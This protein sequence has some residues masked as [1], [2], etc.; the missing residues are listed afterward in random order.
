MFIVI[1]TLEMYPKSM[2]RDLKEAFLSTFSSLPVLH[3]DNP[4]VLPVPRWL[5]FLQVCDVRISNI[6]ITLTSARAAF[7][8]KY[9]VNLKYEYPE[10]FLLI[11]LPLTLPTSSFF[12]Q[13]RH[14]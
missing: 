13:F 4:C 11:F 1:P 2:V 3:T 12:S 14:P 10:S 7:Y 5:H 6:L 8:V 9:S